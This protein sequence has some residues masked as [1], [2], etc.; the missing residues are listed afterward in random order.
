M[1]V[2]MSL[3]TLHQLL[4]DAATAGAKK[5][6]TDAGLVKSTMSK[7]AAYKNMVRVEWMLGYKTI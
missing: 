7:N 4:I 1:N 5:A 6:L 2:K 3:S